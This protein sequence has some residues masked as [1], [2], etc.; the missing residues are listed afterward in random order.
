MEDNKEFDEN[1]LK[2]YIQ[3]QFNELYDKDII[4]TMDWKGRKVLDCGHRHMCDF[5]MLSR[6]SRQAIKKCKEYLKS[7]GLKR[8]DCMVCCDVCKHMKTIYSN[9]NDYDDIIAIISNTEDETN[10]FR[11]DMDQFLWKRQ[12]YN[13]N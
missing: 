7:I 11:N 12:N 8:D 2:E 3:K 9:P 1:Y 5:E 4:K 6:T 13:K 10:R